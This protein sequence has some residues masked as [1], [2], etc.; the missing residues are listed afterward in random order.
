[1]NELSVNLHDPTGHSLAISASPASEEFCREFHDALT[2]KSSQVFGFELRRKYLV[3]QDPTERLHRYRVAG[4]ISN[5]MRKRF[6]SGNFRVEVITDRS[7]FGFIITP[8]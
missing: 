2:G 1:M 8:R 4:T 3:I 7:A 5:R 6:Q